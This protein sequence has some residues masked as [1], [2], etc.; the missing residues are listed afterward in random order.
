[1]L[2]CVRCYSDTDGPGTCPKC[3]GDTVPR[4]TP[5]AME[6]LEQRPKPKQQTFWTSPAFFMLVIFFFVGAITLAAIMTGGT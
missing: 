4:D 3:G 5:R 6:I 1:M 2:V